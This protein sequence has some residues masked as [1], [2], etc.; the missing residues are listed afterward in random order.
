MTLETEIYA[1]PWQVG[2]VQAK[3]MTLRDYFAS[4]AMENMLLGSTPYDLIA[5]YAY[6]A[7]DE[8]MK[9]REQ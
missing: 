6:K 7:A 4:K 5:K 2:A 3:G 9:A 1:F 8:M